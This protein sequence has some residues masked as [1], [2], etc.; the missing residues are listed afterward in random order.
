M[1]TRASGYFRVLAV[2]FDG[3][4]AEGGLPPR[5]TVLDAL[6]AAR[7]QGLLVV[8]VTGRIMEELRETWPS[9][10][11]S[12]DCVV[13]ENGAVLSWPEGHRLLAPPVDERLGSSLAAAGIPFRRGE[14]LLAASV[15]DEPAVLD[16]VRALQLDCQTVANRTELMVVPAGVSKGSGL[17]RALGEFHRLG[18]RIGRGL[19]LQEERL[20]GVFRTLACHTYRW[21]AAAVAC[22]FP[23]RCWRPR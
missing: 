11:T 1:G 6:T 8:L 15:A 2:D 12:V 20:V 22:A 17:H 21:Y 23:N 5:P 18:P 4:L 13:A 7:A 10:A 9:V 14:V 19:D 3:T 16:G